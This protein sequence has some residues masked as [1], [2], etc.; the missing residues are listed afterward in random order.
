[1]TQSTPPR[2]PVHPIDFRMEE[3]G[4]V[5]TRWRASESVSV[6]GVGSVGKSNFL[7]HLANPKI[8]HTMI[9][10]DPHLFQVILIDPRP[11]VTLSETSTNYEQVAGR[12]GYELLFHRIYSCFYNSEFLSAKE[13]HYLTELYSE[14]QNGTTPLLAYAGLRYLELG[15]DLLMLKGIQLVFIFDDFELMLRKLPVSFFV[16]LRCL[17]DAYKRQICFLTFTR[18]PLAETIDKYNI[19]PIEIEQFIELFYSNIVFLGSYNSRDSYRMLNDLARRHN[20]EY[21]DYVKNFLLWASGGFAGLLRAAFQ[22]MVRLGEP[23]LTSILTKSSEYVATLAQTTSVR[24]ECTTIWQS[25]TSNEQEILLAAL[26]LVKFNED[27]HTANAAEYLVRKS[28][29]T[30]SSGTLTIS[31]PLFHYYVAEQS[32]ETA[33]DDQLTANSQPQ[34]APLVSEPIYATEDEGHVFISYSRRDIEVMRQVKLSLGTAGVITWTDENITPGTDLWQTLIEKALENAGCL[35]VLMSPW[36]K[37]SPWVRREIEYAQ[38]FGL[39]VLPLLIHGDDRTAIPLALR[40]T[41]YVD[42]R[43]SY[44]ARISEILSSIHQ[45]CEYTR[46]IRESERKRNQAQAADQD[47]GIDLTEA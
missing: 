6:V 16:M 40:G 10:S 9:A 5:Y 13:Q 28:L 38:S 24:I 18:M 19:D 35:V 22:E 42:V 23:D 26:G 30:A 1:M 8:S 44:D 4:M 21:P 25:L 20:R 34:V 41:Q 7:M 12:L 32:A 14:L 43:K 27:E 2:G 3:T 36:S 46:Q 31:P 39:P 33:H 37:S 15:L 29:L 47:L 11:L 45:Q 17:R